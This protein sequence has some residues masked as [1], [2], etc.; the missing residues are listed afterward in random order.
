MP[1]FCISRSR[2]PRAQPDRLDA[3]DADRSRL[4]MQQ[5]EDALD[6]NRFSGARAADDDEA[7][8][9]AAVDVDAVEHLLAAERLAQSADR[10]LRHCVSV[11]HRPK[12]AAVIR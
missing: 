8:A 11:A 1:N 4:G 3:V 7:L 5:A 10:D 6:Q 2:A 12:K 9:A